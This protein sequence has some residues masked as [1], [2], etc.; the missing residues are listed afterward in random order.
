MAF[1]TVPVLSYNIFKLKCSNIFRTA[2]AC[3]VTQSRLKLCNLMACSPPS[4]LSTGFSRPEHWSGWPRPPPGDLPDPG[5]KPV[6]PALQADSLPT[7]PSGKPNIFRTA[8]NAIKQRK[9]Y[10]KF[11]QL[12]S[13]AW[14]PKWYC[15][16]KVHDSSTRFKVWCGIWCPLSTLFI[17]SL[18][19]YLFILKYQQMWGFFKFSFTLVHYCFCFHVLVFGHRAPEILAPWPGFEPAPMHWEAEF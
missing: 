19:F 12:F 17:S 10:Q 13:W 15:W 7:E 11:C 9:F 6:S 4:S 14:P 5:V 3:L 1:W 16:V 8:V 2:L 18:V